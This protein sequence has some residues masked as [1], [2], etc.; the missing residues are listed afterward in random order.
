MIPSIQS[1]SECAPGINAANHRVN[2][3]TPLQDR[4]ARANIQ[5]FALIAVLAILAV[6]TL[7]VLAFV[8][9]VSQDYLATK[10]YGSSIAADQIALGGLDQVIGQLRQE[11]TNTTGSAGATAEIA[12]GGA[13]ANAFTNYVPFTASAVLP[14]YV[15]NPIVGI[16]SS[17]APL[18]TGGPAALASLSSGHGYTT[19]NSLNNRSVSLTRW[20]KPQLLFTNFTSAQIPQWI[21]VTR[22]GPKQFNNFNSTPSL[23]STLTDNSVIGRYA[24]VIYDTSGLLD[25]TV[26]GY[27]GPGSSAS[28]NTST[29]TNSAA[30]GPVAWADLTQ[31]INPVTHLGPQQSDINTFVAWRNAS[32][33]ANASSY[34]TY[35]T[36]CLASNNFTTVAPGDTTF[37]SRQ[38][39]IK[40]AS[41]NGNGT[42]TNILPYLTTFSRELNGP[43]WYPTTTPP[44]A[45]SYYGYSANAWAA[46]SVGSLLTITNPAVMNPRIG[47]E[48]VWTRRNGTSTILGEP[49]VKYRFPLS[50]LSLLALTSAPTTAQ[51]NQIKQYFGLD[52]ISGTGNPAVDSNPSVGFRHWHYPTTDANYP[53]TQGQILTIFAVQQLATQREPDFF[54]LLQEGILGGS[55]GETGGQ[56]NAL[57][58]NSGPPGWVASPV[59]NPTANFGRPDIGSG[60]VTRNMNDTD[61]S[62]MIQIM[63]IGAN[64]IDQAKADSFPT[65]INV[66]YKMYPIT[67]VSGG[68]SAQAATAS[69]LTDDVYGAEDLPYINKIILKEY[70]S[71]AALSTAYT[72]NSPGP[73]F[74]V[75]VVPELWNPNQVTQT[76]ASLYPANFQVSPLPYNAGVNNGDWM[77][78]GFLNF[79]KADKEYDW[80]WNE[81]QGAWETNHI[82]LSQLQNNG[83]V[84]LES[85][86]SPTHYLQPSLITNGTPT[87]GPWGAVWPGGAIP[88]VQNMYF[89]PPAQMDTANP[90]HYPW[91]SPN[92]STA[93]NSYDTN[94]CGGASWELKGWCDLVL[95][96]QWIDS[97]G[98]AH[99]YGT[100][101]GTDNA[102]NNDG[103]IGA[104]YLGGYPGN[105]NPNPGC[106]TT[107]SSSCFIKNDP[108]S[109][110]FGFGFDDGAAAAVIGTNITGL[111]MLSG[112]TNVNT[113]PTGQVNYP[114]RGLPNS[115]IFR[116]DFWAVNDIA[117]YG[118][119]LQGPNPNSTTYPGWYPDLDGIIRGGDFKYGYV[120]STTVAPSGK[121]GSDKYLEPFYPDAITSYSRPLILHRPFQSVGELGYA[122]R[123]Q[124]WK[125]LD[126]FSPDSADA[127][128]LDLFTA[129]SD[130]PIIA[131]RVS[132]NT[133]YPDVLMALISGGYQNM[134]GGSTNS[135]AIAQAMA[136]TITTSPNAP[137]LNISQLVTTGTIGSLATAGTPVY[138]KQEQEGVI[139]ALAET[140]DTRTWSFMID[141]IAQAGH[142]PTT[143]QSFDDFVVQGERR[144]WLHVAIDRYTG[145][146]I[147]KQLEMVEENF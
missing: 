141:I 5:S 80:Y 39:L 18:F 36:N 127:G 125:S 3:F 57:T 2:T 40:F 103:L 64:I 51:A 100:F 116:W 67:F 120:S 115:G 81:G 92:P 91:V 17:T 99:T 132:L 135:A 138:I 25:A 28:V 97:A 75:Y 27:P 109:A 24:Y 34:V 95:R 32:T 143:A 52:Y 85:S 7:M 146:V 72:T 66:T 58:G 111:P 19:N 78:V 137:F 94:T 102:T 96:S 49:L 140:T 13:G 117:V 20:M 101:V 145:E 21:L 86:M 46:A 60:N 9:V 38:D 104:P 43:T 35:V 126:F 84:P 128:L 65:D 108:R 63:R 114:F 107:V 55:V 44:S 1:Q 31:L 122:F 22:T 4:R 41:Q 124:P 112:C 73:P 70:N 113:A 12:K 82:N 105:L 90:T 134:G 14:Q 54:E 79:K 71:T 48:S 29:M 83:N 33:A 118:N 110:R 119:P 62:S 15:A 131:G 56:L 142:Y 42:I 77:Q 87:A 76:N 123:D 6:F 61:N 26:A 74:S 139:R 10:N 136:N 129:G 130:T 16:S 69:T 89:P 30:K 45:P 106:N 47:A 88:V 50:K 147:G 53:H 11:A 121:G 133:P 8:T 98:N 59:Q 144:Y 68:K 23:S 37:L 93:T